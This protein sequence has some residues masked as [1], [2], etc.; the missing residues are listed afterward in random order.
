MTEKAPLRGVFFLQSMVEFTQ[1]SLAG[2]MGDA[3]ASRTSSRQNL[4]SMRLTRTATCLVV[5]LLGACDAGVPTA[6]LPVL[7][8]VPTDD[9]LPTIQQQ[10]ESLR[11]D[12]VAQP[13]DAGRVGSLGMAYLAYHQNAAA[14]AAL[15][16]ARLL[17]PEQFDWLYFHAEA[18]TRLGRLEEAARSLRL[19]LVQR[20]DHDI[21]RTRLALVL[22][23]SGEF[24]EARELLDSIVAAA[25]RL[26]MARLGLA[27]LLLSVDDPAA[28][29]EH[30]EIL[31][32]QTGPSDDVYFSLANAWRRQGESAK[33]QEFFVLFEKYRGVGLPVNDALMTRVGE[34]DI[35]E[36]PLLRQ[37]RRLNQLGS[38]ERAIELLN[39]AL[40]RNPDNMLVH[41]SLVRAYGAL[42]QFDKVDH[43]Y[44]RALAG[45][46]PTVALLRNLGRARFYEGRYAEARMAFFDAQTR[47]PGDSGTLAWLGIIADKQGDEARAERRFLEALKYNPRDILACYSFGQLLQR[48]RRFSEARTQFEQLFVPEGELTAKAMIMIAQGLAA[49]DGRDE[50]RELLESATE[51]ATR[52]GKPKQ[53][54]QAQELLAE[55][56]Q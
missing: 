4:S 43:H 18:L 22:T 33:S 8:A 9:F 6:V 55:L 39:I 13:R 15:H 50:A 54:R 16:T 49:Q 42:R 26:A 12:V 3:N 31:L 34:F 47:S 20:P 32:R 37:A 24:D 52:L 48:Q 40:E 21:A 41:A 29:V 2:I 44:Q 35:S 11:A 38:T 46:P 56:P 27:R 51:I 23:Q 25:P 30:L 36:K 17:D 45:G 28:A 53:V 10:L 19:A 14:E 7:P 5:L 1:L